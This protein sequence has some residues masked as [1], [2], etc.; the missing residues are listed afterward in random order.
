MSKGE[1]EVETNKIGTSF[2]KREIQ[3]LTLPLLAEEKIDFFK[4]ITL[5]DFKVSIK[6]LSNN[7]NIVTEVKNGT[8]SGRGSIALALGPEDH[9]AT[10]GGTPFSRIA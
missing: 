8:I 9:C 4:K 2:N 6:N 7:T 10:A 1:V 5:Q 3:N